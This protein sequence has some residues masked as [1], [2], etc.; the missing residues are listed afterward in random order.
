MSWKKRLYELEVDPP[1]DV[2]LKLSDQLDEINADNQVAEKLGILEAQPPQSAWS[3]IIAALDAE[4]KSPAKLVRMTGNWKRIAAAAVI[5]GLIF[6]SYFIFIQYRN[7][8]REGNVVTTGPAPIQNT[9]P[10]TENRQETI[11]TPAIDS[12]ASNSGEASVNEHRVKQTEQN[13]TNPAP[14]IAR[15]NN[16]RNNLPRPRVTAALENNDDPVSLVRNEADVSS[17]KLEE[18]SFKASLEDLAF[19]KS[20]NGY[21]TMVTADGRLVNIPL[22]YSAIAP[23]LQ[24]KASEIKYLDLLFEESDYWKSKFNEWK[25]KLGQPTVT[26][27]LDNFF[28][29]VSMLKAMEE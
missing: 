22:K 20:H 23:Y 21:L 26:P 17:A 18:S 11:L 16:N 10:Q 24:D 1:A 25:S 9:V 13:S 3:R 2:W 19:V 14:V 5:A 12:S 27:S 28:N 29:L 7:S 4:V 15:N 8:D 6:A